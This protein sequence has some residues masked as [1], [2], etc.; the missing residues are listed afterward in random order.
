[1]TSGDTKTAT[2]FLEQ[3]R[4][5]L[6]ANGLVTDSAD[7]EP[8]LTDW[9]GR[10]HGKAM[11][12]AQPA[13]SEQLAQLVALCADAG[14]PIVAQ[15]GN[16]GMVGGATPDE[17]GSAIVLS[18]RR[19]TDLAIDCEARLARCGAGVVLQVLHEASEAQGLRFPLSLG[20]KGS[21]T[22]GGLISTNAGGTQVLRHGVMRT[23]VAG[24]EVVLADGRVLN[25]TSA[26]KKDN[27][28]FDLKQMFIGSEGTLGI[29]TSAVLHL[30]PAIADR[31]VVIA[32]TQ[33]IQEARS[34]MLDCEREMRDSL[35]AFEVFPRS[36]LDAVLD[37]MPDAQDPLDTPYPWYAVLEFVA[38]RAGA[39]ALGDKVEEVL[40]EAFENGL[41]Q[42]AVIAASEAQAEAF[43]QL[44]EVISP[45]EK[46]KGPA[47]QH[48]ISVPVEKMPDFVVAVS[49][50]VLDRHS[51]HEVAA[52]GHLGDGN[53]HF[54]V[55]APP[56]SDRTEWESTKG[57][58]ISA[59]V[60]DLVTR[61][62]GSISAEH[63][64]GQDKLQTLRETAD[65]NVLDVMRRVK[66]ALDP[67]NL[68]NPGKLV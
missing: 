13:N 63:G 58:E 42:N 1:M 11:A 3:A 34:L 50:A 67:D 25:L 7:I 41:C 49:K 43:W 31:R 47:M 65:P 54:H 64:I 66:N 18:T 8:W 17:S 21:A 36:C 15:G 51:D 61:W 45:A 48:D 2:A 62:G 19:L 39:D 53:V 27:R 20:G 46:A 52:F 9:R 33:T 38:D 56:G 12:M 10:Y 35:E 14:V 37:Y 68:L 24:I 28:G 26:L 57:K 59:F 55:I 44:R 60:Y 16:S 29:I 22:V 6:G 32:A 30:S 5:L 23:L 4:A 40:A